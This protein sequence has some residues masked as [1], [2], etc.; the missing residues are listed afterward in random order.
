MTLFVFAR[1]ARGAN[2]ATIVGITDTGDDNA[3]LFAHFK[4]SFE[5][6]VPGKVIGPIFLG[7]ELRKPVNPRI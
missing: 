4:Q 7:D 1:D 6:S 2:N 5:R 3:S